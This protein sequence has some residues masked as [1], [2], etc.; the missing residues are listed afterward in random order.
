VNALYR[1]SAARHLPPSHPLHVSR[2][3]AGKE[4]RHHK[5]MRERQG[6]ILYLANLHAAAT[7]GSG[8]LAFKTI[9]LKLTDLRDWVYD[10]R[11][12]LDHFFEVAQLGFNV[13]PDN[14][15]ISTLIPRS[16]PTVEQIAGLSLAYQPGP[17]PED[18][19]TI[20]K[21]YIAQDQADAIRQRLRRSGLLNLLPPVDYL[22]SQGEVNFHFTRAGKL[23]QRDTSIWPVAAVETWPS[24]LREQLFGPGLDIDSAYTQFL[25]QELRTI[26]ADR[27]QLLSILYPDL[28]AL[29]EDKQAWR[30]KMAVTLGRPWNSET[31]SLIKQVTM[32][33]ANGS[34]ISPKILQNGQG[35]SSTAEALN[36]GR[37][38]SEEDLERIGKRLH[39]IERQYV[40]AKK[41]VCLASKRLNPTAANQKLIFQDYFRWE[42]EARYLIW[43][44][45]DQHGIMV[46]DGIDGIPTEY[47]DRLPEIIQQVGV[48]LT[49]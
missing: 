30:Q 17:V 34:R 29:M 47:L 32:S 26:Y 1:V 14:N 16:L 27:P 38:L 44:A 22:L 23:Q 43:E 11:T 12:A 28:V 8:P 18:E 7:T 31:V 15:E 9:R 36:Q 24:W 20:S 19:T 49:R 6:L 35:F 40:G 42:R 10:Y 33:L 45:V 46:H 21:V 25:M 13:G 2:F 3:Y 41:Q 37:E 4:R 5:L 39:E 48:R